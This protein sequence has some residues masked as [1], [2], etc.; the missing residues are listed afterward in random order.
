MVKTRGVFRNQSNIYDRAFLR[1]YV[2][3]FNRYFR[4]KNS[5]AN[6]QLGSKY[7]TEYDNKFFPDGSKLKLKELRNRVLRNILV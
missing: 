2:T 6:V 5:I 7:A 3:A 1:K 4:E